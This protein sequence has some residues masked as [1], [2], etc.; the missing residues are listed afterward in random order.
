MDVLDDQ[1]S[2]SFHRIK[3]IYVAMM[4]LYLI[5]QSIKGRCRGNQTLLP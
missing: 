5:F 2:Q 1:F 3:A 4:D